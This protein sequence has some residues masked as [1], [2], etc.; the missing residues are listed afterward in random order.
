MS[1]FDRA[2]DEPVHDAALAQQNQRGHRIHL[3]KTS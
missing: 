1:T 2:G 3:R